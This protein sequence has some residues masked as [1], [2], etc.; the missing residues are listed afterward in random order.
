MR[1]EGNAARALRRRADACNDQIMGRTPEERAERG[2]KKEEETPLSKGRAGRRRYF[3]ML[4][5]WVV[6]LGANEGTETTGQNSDPVTPPVSPYVPKYLGARVKL[7]PRPI[8]QSLSKPKPNPNINRA[9]KHHEP[10]PAP[11]L[12]E[13]VT[14]HQCQGSH[15]PGDLDPCRCRVYAPLRHS[16]RRSESPQTP[17]CRSS[18]VSGSRQGG[19]RDADRWQPV[20]GPVDG[21]MAL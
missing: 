8:H 4:G 2:K 16:T 6:H 17:P 14:A 11:R 5:G 3:R 20:A 7:K 18:P 19:P 10:N 15:T 13:A 21:W 12:D 9:R 1:K